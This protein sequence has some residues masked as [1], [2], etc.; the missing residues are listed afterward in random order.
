MM[1]SLVLGRDAFISLPYHMAAARYPQRFGLVLRPE[2]ATF[3]GKQKKTLFQQCYI[4][5]YH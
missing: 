5:W 1:M 4:L 3:A 2:G